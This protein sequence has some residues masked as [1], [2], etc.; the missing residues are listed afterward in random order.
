MQP[1]TVPGNVDTQEETTDDIAQEL[2]LLQHS[3]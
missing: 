1:A 2:Y 3:R